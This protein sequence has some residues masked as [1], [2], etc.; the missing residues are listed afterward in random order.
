MK[1]VQLAKAAKRLY[2][3]EPSTYVP[4]GTRFRDLN[5]K[6]VWASVID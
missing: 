1:N 4:A 5:Q 6:H 3:I 2:E